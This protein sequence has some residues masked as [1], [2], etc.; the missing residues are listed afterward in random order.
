MINSTGRRTT[1]ACSY[2]GGLWPVSHII[3]QSLFHSF[4][5]TS[6]TA[7]QFKNDTHTEK[8]FFFHLLLSLLILSF[9]SLSSFPLFLVFLSQICPW[10]MSPLFHN[11]DAL[12]IFG[13]QLL[14]CLAH[15]WYYNTCMKIICCDMPR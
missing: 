7:T 8:S 11:H 15:I 5:A 2:V 1:H 14:N 9:L 6:V 4:S 3:E 13:T 12:D 10:S